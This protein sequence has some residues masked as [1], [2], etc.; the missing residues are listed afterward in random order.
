MPKKPKHPCS[1]PGCPNLTDSRFCTEHA[2]EEA[3]RYERYDRD[4]AT[5]RRYGSAWQRVRA[6]YAAAHPLCEQCLAEGRYTATEQVHH[7]KPLAEGGTHDP[8]N[9]VALCAACHARLHA[10]RG[11]RWGSRRDR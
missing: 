2:K 7:I 10:K 6:A 11:D 8:D 4:P 9:L 5:R 1:R 3:R